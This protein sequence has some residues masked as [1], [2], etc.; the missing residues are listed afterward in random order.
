MAKNIITDTGFWYAVYDPKDEHHHAANEIVELLDKQNVY[1][2]WPC[3]YETIN[4]RFAKRK[5]FMRQVEFFINKTNVYLID[6]EKY[7]DVS[8]KLAFEYARIGKRPFSLVDLVL[9]E[10]LADD[11]YKI[12]YLF[13]FNVGDFIDVCN[14]RKIE[15]YC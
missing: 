5:D 3:L 15:I 7:K 12:D 10:I 11:S 2:P 1:L 9:R 4:T 14:K 8:L 13:T 6:D